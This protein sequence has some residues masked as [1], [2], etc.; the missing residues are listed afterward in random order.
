MSGVKGGCLR[1]NVMLWVFELLNLTELASP[2]WEMLAISS[3][4]ELTKD[5]RDSMTWS[6][7]GFLEKVVELCKVE[8]S[9]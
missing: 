1:E 7:E 8:S 9:A 6:V 5:W 3:F 2:H 4:N